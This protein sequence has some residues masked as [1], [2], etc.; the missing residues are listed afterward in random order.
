[1]KDVAEKGFITQRVYP[2]G[3]FMLARP[4]W[5][6]TVLTTKARDRV[7]YWTGARDQLFPSSPDA[8]HFARVF[9]VWLGALT[10]LPVFALAARVTGSRWAGVAAAA[11]L[12]FSP[13]HIEHSHY[14][15]TD[16]A[17]VF[18]LAVS[19]WLWARHVANRTASAFVAAALATGFAA[20]TKFTLFALV[21]V[22]LM[23][24]VLMPPAVPRSR[25]W[26]ARA[27][28]WVLAGLVLCA[29]GFACANPGLQRFSWW[30]AGLKEAAANVYAETPGIMGAAYGDPVASFLKNAR[31]LRHETMAVGYGW[32][33]LTAVSVL[34]LGSRTV[35]KHALALLVFPLV[36]AYYF[37][38]VAPWVRPQEALTFQ[39]AMAVAAAV[40]L[41]GVARW[42]WTR[43]APL[44]RG[45]PA[46]LAIA[47]LL[48]TVANG[49]QRAS[50]FGWVEPRMAALQWLQTCAPYDRVLGTEKYTI[51][52][53]GTM[54]NAKNVYKSERA[55][56]EGIRDAGCDYVVRNRHATGRGV[57]DPRTGQPF[58]EYVPGY[59]EF[60][61]QTQVIRTWS[62][63]GG[64]EWC[65][66][67]CGSVIELVGTH[68][69]APET[70]LEIP[71]T[72]PLRVADEG[73]VTFFPVGQD[74]GPC[75]GVQLDRYPREIGIGGPLDDNEP[76][77]LVLNTLEREARVVVRGPG[78]N[79]EVSLSPYD[80]CVIPV[81]GASHPRTD[82]YQRITLW[83]RPQPHI[84]YV[85]CYAR[86]VAGWRQR[87]AVCMQLGR[88]DMAGPA[89]EMRDSPRGAAVAY[90]LAVERR[91]WAE[92][93]RLRPVAEACDTRLRDY[94]AGR[95]QRASVGGGD[96]VYQEEFA[97]IRLQPVNVTTTMALR[98]DALDEDDGRPVP[99]LPYGGRLTVPV[100][101]PAGRYRLEMQVSLEK[102]NAAGRLEVIDERD[103][104]LVTASLSEMAGR[105]V[106]LTIPL[107]GG[108]EREPTL[109]FLSDRRVNLLV[110]RNELR[111]TA[112][113]G[114]QDQAGMLAAALARHDLE[115][116]NPL[117]AV[118][119][120]AGVPAEGA[121]AAEILRL[122]F[123]AETCLSGEGATGTVA[124]ARALHAYAPSHAKALKCLSKVDPSLAH[125]AAAVEGNLGV[126]VVFGQHLAL[127]GFR[128]NPGRATST[129]VVE[130]LTDHCP[131][132]AISLYRHNGKK[133]K[134][135]AAQPV[136]RGRELFAGERVR[137][138]L[139]WPG[140]SAKEVATEAAL[141][142][143]VEADVE[144]LAG[145]LSVAES[146]AGQV[147]L[148]S[149]RELAIAGKE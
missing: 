139:V 109:R 23:H 138:E 127:V 19:L 117:A 122:R 49:M 97:R 37:L 30:V 141:A 67:F 89:E 13:Q 7:R 64:T 10:C 146:G 81:T 38:R 144:W 148:A 17:M 145:R 94:L 34:W 48:P 90:G 92:A 45:L 104:V 99:G 55:G 103:Q 115:R 58:E 52:L 25:G 79:R 125:A 105:H 96:V 130:A 11:F 53:G 60:L 71:V 129:L 73:R 39:P 68:G 31:L 86:L 47:A 134:R 132:L 95:I 131:P 80:V 135:F 74:L 128:H 69:A 46:L 51:P 35:R 57:M 14:A 61:R 84:V 8:L 33:L 50:L 27:A 85:P 121:P 112:R 9:N 126:P 147:S 87:A 59:E 66:V 123:E 54:E 18:T 102:T 32:V 4:A 36:F 21:P 43:R 28:G 72:Q 22:F 42:A 77:Y 62:P 136:A 140:V 113:D 98:L 142:L 65:G 2:N 110:H 106:A 133:W 15:E 24:A 120:L 91:E 76:V 114:I 70:D 118:T 5:E 29:V 40:A 20:G 111:W 88:P 83:V 1:M 107:A 119:R 124:A 116:G 75:T 100:R 143:G 137:L 93:D 3:F 108:G 149:L 44:W 26:P 16:I 6:V 12:A 41:A 101:L 63:L 78:C 82:Q 56:F